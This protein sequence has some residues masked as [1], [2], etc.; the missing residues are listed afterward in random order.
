MSSAAQRGSASAIPAAIAAKMNPIAYMTTTRAMIAS[1]AAMTIAFPL[2]FISSVTSSICR[3]TSR[4]RAGLHL[5]QVGGDPEH[6]TARSET[7]NVGPWVRRA[8]CRRRPR[9]ASGRRECPSRRD[10]RGS[11]ARHPGCGPV[12]EAARDAETEAEH[13]RMPR[14]V[15]RCEGEAAAGSSSSLE[16]SSTSHRAS[17]QSSGRPAASRSQA[18]AKGIPGAVTF[19]A[20]AAPVTSPADSSSVPR[21]P[22][23]SSRSSS[24]RRRLGPSG[25]GGRHTKVELVTCHSWA[26]WPRAARRRGTRPPPARRRVGVEAPTSPP[27][28]LWRRRPTGRL[29][30]WPQHRLRPWPRHGQRGNAGYRR[31]ACGSSHREMLLDPA[32]RGEGRGAVPRRRAAGLPARCHRPGGGGSRRGERDGGRGRVRFDPPRPWARARARLTPERAHGRALREGRGGVARLRRLDAPP[33]R[34]AR[35]SRRQRGR[36]RRPAD[37]RRRGARVP[38]AR[39]A[40]GRGGVLR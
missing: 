29:A 8:A 17:L 16:R 28:G 14:R 34:R 9:S 7:T 35:E 11:V 10:A 37:D 19:S 39:R 38:D 25:A 27:A 12:A 31:S 24:R 13:A 33:R 1:A 30:P 23:L 18:A 2:R 5:L 40:A 26:E 15:D 32:L 3:R 21:I 6:Q 36:R 22:S 20:E 4:Y